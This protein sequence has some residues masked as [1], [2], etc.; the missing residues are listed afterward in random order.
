MKLST[1]SALCL[2]VFA[3]IAAAA[4]TPASQ[5]SSSTTVAVSKD[6]Y[7]SK[8]CPTCAH[9]GEKELKMN[10][11]DGSDTKILL[12]FA[13]PEAALN[14]P[15]KIE[16]CTLQLPTPN[17]VG[18]DINR[19]TM[20]QVATADNA[21]WDE[22]KVNYSN[23]PKSKV[24]IEEGTLQK[25]KTEFDPV[26]INQICWDFAKDKNRKDNN[27]NLYIFGNKEDKPLSFSSKEGGSP[28]KLVVKTK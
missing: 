16:S 14:G 21:D 5:P 22:S 20:V 25:G 1:I 17:V 3:S 13:I 11:A 12:R 23:A 19:Y 4:P 24:W 15:D 18:R 8:S 26:N 28:I 9:G 10:G 27:L 7:I 6:T 2:S